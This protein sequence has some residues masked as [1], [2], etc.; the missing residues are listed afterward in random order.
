MGLKETL[1]F[2]E[3]CK[4]DYPEK[5]LK[6]LTGL[7][8]GLFRASDGKLSLEMD[9]AVGPDEDLNVYWDDGV[10]HMNLEVSTDELPFWFYCNRS[11]ESFFGEEV[12]DVDAPPPDSIVKAAEA[13]YV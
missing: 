2:F 13:F 11:D 10:H 3:S 8:Y 5:S 6:I 7:I 4:G 1:S 9:A 12:E